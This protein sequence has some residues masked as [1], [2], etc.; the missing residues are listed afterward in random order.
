MAT[1]TLE[2]VH[3][4]AVPSVS[5]A[6][7]QRESMEQKLMTIAAGGSLGIDDA[8]L[9]YCHDVYRKIARGL[10][11]VTAGTLPAEVDTTPAVTDPVI[12]VTH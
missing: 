2:P 12:A 8:I 4:A 9:Q 10:L 5:I 3:G 7:V 6:V 1:V 11:K